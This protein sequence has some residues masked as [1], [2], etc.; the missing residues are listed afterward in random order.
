MSEAEFYIQEGLIEEARKVYLSILRED[1]T[2]EIASRKLQEIEANLQTKEAVAEPAEAIAPEPSEPAP[3]EPIL[4]EPVPADTGLPESTV[5][6]LQE[7]SAP[8]AAFE[9]AAEPEAEEEAA[10]P[11]APEPAA[12]AEP[13]A[14]EAVSASANEQFDLQAEI[15]AEAG[16]GEDKSWYVEPAPPPATDLFD[17]TG[18]E[19]GL[20]DLAAEL[21][22]DEDAFPLP[23]SDSD[24]SMGVDSEFAAFKKGVN[25]QVSES[26]S[27]TRYD[28]GH[29]LPGNGPPR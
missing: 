17:S 25:Q 8:A 26:D 18:E 13:A 29:R 7:P 3:A 12:V 27:A 6:E 11:P 22:K 5:E 21:E 9:T 14:P 10:P 1:P 20:F 24:D 23:A 15:R 19:S 4:L 16:P 28:L 2:H